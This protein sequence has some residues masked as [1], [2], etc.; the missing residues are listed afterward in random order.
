[1]SRKVILAVVAP[2]AVVLVTLAGLYRAHTKLRTELAE[3]DWQ[4]AL[5]RAERSSDA[6]QL[7]VGVIQFLRRGYSVTLDSVTYEQNG[8][9][10]AG[11]VGNPHLH[12]VS[13]LT[14]DFAV[15][16]PLWTMRDKYLK[17]QNPFGL[18]P[19]P[20]GKAQVSVRDLEPGAQTRFRVIVPNV[21]Q[22][23]EQY[24]VEIRFSGERYSYL[25]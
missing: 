9:R 23:N 12:T 21:G 20:V 2:T 15:H 6:I 7:Q 3:L 24:E 16:Q 19:D 5:A 13:S 8:V 18:Y 25:R 1:M 14:L 11:R 4:L 17:E 10:L 22:S